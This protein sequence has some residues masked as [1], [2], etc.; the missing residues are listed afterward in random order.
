MRSKAALLLCTTAL[1]PIASPAK[2]EPVTLFFTGLTASIGASAATA[3]VASA[4][5]GSTLLGFQ[6]GS[7]LFGTALG[8]VVLS[9]GLSAVANSLQRRPPIPR[10]SER[11]VN[12]AQ[13]LS[14]ME[15]AFG[16]VRKGGPYALT[17]FQGDRRHYAVIL[18][19]HSILGVEQWYLDQRP[20][21]VDGDGSVLT[22]P[23]GTAISALPGDSAISLR[24]RRG[25][26]GQVADPILVSQ[27]PEWTSAHNMAGLAYVAAFARRVKDENFGTVYGNSPGTGPAIAPA[28]RAADTIYDPRT[29]S[30]GWNDNAALVFAWI[31]TNVLGGEV[32]WAEIAEEADQADVLVANR[33]GALQRKWTLNGVFDEQTDVAEIIKQIIAA[34]DAYVYERPDGSIGFMVGRYIEPTITLTEDDFD[35]LQIAERDWGPKPATEWVGRY[36]EPGFDWNEAVTGVWVEDAQGRAV[37]RDPGLYFV[38]DHNQ[39]IRAIK[40][41]ARSVRAQYSVQGAIRAI[42]YELVNGAGGRAH[43]FVR[44]QAYG[45]DFV[46]EIGRISRGE[47]LTSLSIE[48]TS[49]TPEDFGFVAAVEEPERPPREK[50]SNDNTVGAPGGLTGE[51]LPGGTIRWSWTA[52][53]GN[54]TQQLRWREIGAPEWQPAIA[55]PNAETSVVIGNLSDG[56]F[57]ES[58]LSNL[59]ASNRRSGWHGPVTVQAI[60][61]P[62]A[63]AALDAFSVTGA[64]SD[65]DIDFQT[66]NDA[67]YAA[68]RIYRAGYPVAYGGPYA[69]GDASLIATIYG[70]P[71]AAQGADNTG[72]PDGNYA[73]WAAPINSSGIQGPISG[74]AILDIPV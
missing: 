44:V 45:F 59:T 32:D 63:P 3:A 12:F 13:P 21:E 27:I 37:R 72:L 22:E 29:D 25:E 65:V 9:L 70:P 74:P 17:S 54:L 24:L 5:G 67:N 51:A 30:F 68:T 50:V 8:Q 53:P 40:R 33:T 42:G 47:Q 48:G 35:S 55:I 61:N 10:P 43:R 69:I 11:L 23:Y 1:T 56:A 60:V 4:I 66:P 16:L 62:I 36:V 26:P 18:C 38:D 20:V 41:I 57:Y 28:I 34:C 14:A 71:N 58:E 39:A 19:A 73:Y 64:G 2:G 7:F 46:M 52:Q 6:V 31:I 49:V 15:W